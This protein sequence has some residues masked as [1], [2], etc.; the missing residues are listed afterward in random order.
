MHKD[1]PKT[2]KIHFY[3]Y[4][5]Y[6]KY[7]IKVDY[8]SEWWKVLPIWVDQL[9]S[10]FNDTRSY[11]YEWLKNRIELWF[12]DKFDL[13]L[14]KK[15][16]IK[17]AQNYIL[18]ILLTT[19]TKEDKIR[20]EDISDGITNGKYSIISPYMI[21]TQ[22]ELFFRVNNEEEKEEEEKGKEEK[23]EEKFDILRR[24]GVL[25]DDF[26]IFFSN[27][28]LKA[29]KQIRRLFREIQNIPVDVLTKIAYTMFDVMYGSK[30]YP[31]DNFWFI[32]GKMMLT[33][34][35]AP[36]PVTDEIFDILM[37][38]DKTNLD[39][40]LKYININVKNSAGSL[41]LF[42]LTVKRGKYFNTHTKYLLKKYKNT[43]DI[44]IKD[45]RENTM[46]IY[47]VKYFNQGLAKYLLKTFKN[48]IDINI[49]NQ[50]GKTALIYSVIHNQNDIVD[51]LLNIKKIDINIKD[52]DKKNAL[53]YAIKNDI[54]PSL[55]I[56]EYLINKGAKYLDDDGITTEK[57]HQLKKIVSPEFKR[58]YLGLYQTLCEISTQE[59]QGCKNLLKQA[60]RTLGIT[61]RKTWVNINPDN[62]IISFFKNNKTPAQIV[63]IHKYKFIGQPGIDESGVTKMYWNGIGNELIE[64]G[65]FI[66]N[67]ETGFGEINPVFNCRKQ[68]KKLRND[69]E[70][71][72][73][74][75]K[76]IN[77]LENFDQYLRHHGIDD[78]ELY[79][80]IGQMFAK[81]F[82][83][84]EP[85][86]LRLSFNIL[87][88]LVYQKLSKNI[89]GLILYLDDPQVFNSLY[90]LVGKKDT[91][92]RDYFSN[93]LNFENIGESPKKV[94]F[95]NYDEF[96]HKKT[97]WLLDINEKEGWDPSTK[98]IKNV[99]S[100]EDKLSGFVQGFNSIIPR[101]IINKHNVKDIQDKINGIDLTDNIIRKW[102]N[103][104]RLDRNINTN[105]EQE[106]M[107]VFKWFKEI[108]TTIPKTGPE[109]KL[110]YRFIQ[111][112]IVFIT[113]KTSLD[114]SEKNEHGFRVTVDMDKKDFLPSVHVCFNQIVLG[115]YDSKQILLEKLKKIAFDPKYFTEGTDDAGGG[116][117]KNHKKTNKLKKSKPKRKH[118]GINQ[119]TGGLKKSKPKRKH[120]GIN[121][122]TGGLKKGFKYSGK[123]LKSGL[124]EI[125]KVKKIKN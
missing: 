125:I 70:K 1:S 4:T 59:S 121:Q 53:F 107:D 117:R 28:R 45:G 115:I 90:N 112:L 21:N 116:R 122:Q 82:L 74:N 102:A 104:M 58:K 103:E 18:N 80:K 29:N 68:I 83:V 113:G 87:Y 33:S 97:K 25:S 36:Y 56:S 19:L 98:T 60:H 17:Y 123:K 95:K 39:K 75:E 76:V 34:S 108:I 14:R 120:S 105:W 91:Y 51:M 24:I 99:G 35:S 11:V 42:E 81:A 40:A 48:T 110:H 3:K 9:H 62:K 72:N 54:I 49:Q 63:S 93:E 10:I 106:Q 118:S 73:E 8:N 124:P 96:I 109:K 67:E 92:V 52:N 79:K 22:M 94:T 41:L 119:Q 89:Y 23:K 100:W 31:D 7:H 114:F 50:E 16:D 30:D 32:F 88:R 85:L 69:D 27:T 6:D 15:W 46:L 101:E 77:K 64:L 37:N 78:F 55:P 2:K 20:I 43:I 61:G 13:I 5:K 38:L 44:N 71:E 26:E 57:C 47:T 12:T 66:K 86:N 84:E 65:L 111:R